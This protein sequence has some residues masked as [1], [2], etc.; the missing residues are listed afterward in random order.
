[1]IVIAV[2]DERHA[3]ELLEEAIREAVPGCTLETFASASEALEYAGRNVV[4]VA[5]LDV[6]MPGI[7]GLALARRLRELYRQTNVVFVTGYS[8]Y[9]IDAFSVSASGYV[10][11][12]VGVD[13]IRREMKN[14]RHLVR[15]PSMFP[16][17]GVWV[18]T[19]GHF[20][21]FVDGKP[22]VFKLAKSKEILAYLVDRR[23]SGVEKKE[24]ATILW[25][26]DSYTRNR[27]IYLQ[28]LISGM[29]QALGDVGAADIVLRWSGNLA[30]D[31][32][33]VSCDYYNFISGDVRAINSY[34]DEY[35]KNY[36]WAEFTAAVLSKQ[37]ETQ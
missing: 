34:Q 9:A 10:M 29:I 32:S 30:V 4:D 16:K 36:S 20:E 7:G 24:L 2:D 8:D 21:V 14:L 31:T 18:Q 37:K 28:T 33:K 25:N 1:M 15:Y 13:A 17:E 6:E 19:F 35:M 3:L 22:V 5:F 27:Q 23:G 26:E 11:K 12:P